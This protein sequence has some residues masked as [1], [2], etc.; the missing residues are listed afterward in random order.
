MEAKFESFDVSFKHP[1]SMVVAGASGSGK[2]TWVQKLIKSD[3]NSINFER[4]VWCYGASQDVDIPGV[5]LVE[6]VDVHLDGRPTLVVLDDLM[7]A[8]ANSSLV[9]D[10]FS[11]KS[12]HNN[13]SVILLVQNFFAQGRYMRTITLNSH[14][15]VLFKSPRDSSFVSVL[16]RQMYPNNASFLAQAYKHA[17]QNPHSNLLIDLKQSTGEKIRVRSNVLSDISV[18]YMP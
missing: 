2:T 9:S 5:E 15:I 13:C 18:V 17:S 12:H 16:G 3:Y 6:G 1:Y 14:Y 4:I 7:D 8:S 10:L 11:K